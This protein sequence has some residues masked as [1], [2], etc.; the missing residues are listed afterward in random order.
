[1]PISRR[2]TLQLGALLLAASKMMPV[3]ALAQA[4][5][6]LRFGDASPFSFE[7]LI[8][9]ARI[10]ASA[11][12]IPPPQPSPDIV[13]RIDY[14]AHGRLDYVP[15]YALYAAGPGVYPITFRHMG[16]YF[17][18]SVRMFAVEGSN[19]RE[20]LYDPRYF[21]IETDYPAAELPPDVNAFAGFGVQESRRIGDWTPVQPWVSF[22]GASYFRPVGELNQVGLSARGIALNSGGSEPEEFPDFTAFWFEPTLSEGDPVIVYALLEGPSVTGAYKF[23]MTRS[24]IILVEVEKYLFFRQ[25]V[26]R[27]GVAPLTSMFWYGEFPVWHAHDWRP[28]VHDSDTLVLWT[29]EGRH[30][31]RPLTNPP[32][33][34]ISSFYDKNPRGFGLAQRDRNYDHYLDGVSYDRRPT[35]WVE[36]L[37]DWGAGAVQL[38]EIPTDDEIYDNIVTFWHGA[39]D[40]KAGEER[41]YHYRLHWVADEPFFPVRDLAQAVGTRVGRGGEPGKVRHDDILKFVIEWDGSILETI[42]Y[43]ERP[44]VKATASRGELSLMR[45]EPIWYTPRWRSEF[46]LR[47]DGEDVIELTCHLELD[48]VPITERWAFQWFPPPSQASQG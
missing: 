35:C 32:R 41:H 3:Q 27:L 48:G 12:Y 2:N 9:R 14:D 24:K 17:T 8:E 23:A 16:R 42:P 5:S 10:L 29:G 22:Q 20:I 18:K 28:E 1:M 7:G 45:T 26:Q 30:I 44:V 38:I 31:A 37:H 39:N 43:G 34:G 6:S 13:E 25:D 11:P 36:P 46:D 4:S 33:I 15:D 40:P 21:T 47:A 19:A